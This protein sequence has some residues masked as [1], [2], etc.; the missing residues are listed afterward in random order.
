M[1]SCSSCWLLSAT[2]LSGTFCRFSVRSASVTTNSCRAPL[3]ACSCASAGWMA[4]NTADA[5][6]MARTA[7]RPHGLT[8]SLGFRT[9][10]VIES[11]LRRCSK[12]TSYDVPWQ[13]IAE[14]RDV[15]VALQQWPERA[16][17]RPEPRLEMTP[18]FKGFGVDRL[19]NLLGARGADRTR[20]LVETQA[21][22]FVRQAA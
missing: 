14:L 4:A 10:L 15:R 13:I 16:L 12:A 7:Q 19:P 22:L 20:V 1:L 21:T 5:I 11:P 8:V 18:M 17:Q 9:R 2:M 3:S 6:G